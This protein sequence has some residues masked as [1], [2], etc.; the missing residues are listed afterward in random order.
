MTRGRH[1][2]A[3]FRRKL[4]PIE[5]NVWRKENSLELLFKDVSNF[6][7][8]NPVIGSLLREIDLE[9]KQTSSSLISKAPNINDIILKQR[10]DRLKK[11]DER[12]NNGDDDDNNDQG[13]GPEAPPSP[14][15]FNFLEPAA[16]PLSPPPPILAPTSPELPPKDP[17]PTI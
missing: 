11:R 9:K 12:Y 16:P 1:N 13:P 8:Q 10:F 2:E 7:V 5:T 4:D 3:S 15:N 6:D 17:P 14:P